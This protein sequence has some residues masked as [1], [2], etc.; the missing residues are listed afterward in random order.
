MKPLV[1]YI[2]CLTF[3]IVK[4]ILVQQIIFAAVVAATYAAPQY[5]SAPI[6]DPTPVQIP[7]QDWAVQTWGQ[8]DT[9][10]SF[11]QAPVVEQKP[12]IEEIQAQW[13]RFLEHLPWLRGPPGPPGAPG[14]PGVAGSDGGFAGKCF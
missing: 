12:T 1:Y 7:Q 9:V 14:A 3:N 6:P 4:S 13:E 8:A 11:N 5:G 10:S 2:R